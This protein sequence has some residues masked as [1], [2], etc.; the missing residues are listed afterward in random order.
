MELEDCKPNIHFRST[1]SHL[2]GWV[3]IWLQ[4]GL[5]TDH[6]KGRR[7]MSGPEVGAE[8]ERAEGGEAGEQAQRLRVRRRQL[9]AAE[10]DLRV[11][12]EFCSGTDW[13]FVRNQT[14]DV[15]RLFQG[16]RRH[17]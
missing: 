14:E 1:S 16:L 11:S 6:V 9:E 12:L 8:A 4:L 7:Q 13:A 2:G 15:D 5:I 10:V 3:L 17:S